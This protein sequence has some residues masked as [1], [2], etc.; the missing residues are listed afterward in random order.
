MKKNKI[1]KILLISIIIVIV[2]ILLYTALEN[3]YY[4]NCVSGYNYS[5]KLMNETQYNEDKDRV[6]KNQS[7]LFCKIG[8]KVF[9][10]PNIQQCC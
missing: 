1:L 2:F 7:K 8:E 4:T 9:P 10:K 5:R 3:T 6:F